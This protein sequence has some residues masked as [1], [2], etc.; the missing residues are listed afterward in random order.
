MRLSEFGVFGFWEGKMCSRYALELENGHLDFFKEIWS[1]R[2][3]ARIEINNIIILIN[4]GDLA[5]T[6]HI[7]SMW[8]HVP[9]WL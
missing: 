4:I 9:T 5:S 2:L 6:L 7:N 3:A 1:S 8:S